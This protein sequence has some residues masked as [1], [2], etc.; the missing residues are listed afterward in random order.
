MSDHA[1][2][3]AAT[4]ALAAACWAVWWY[5]PDLLAAL[6]LDDLDIP[7]RVGAVI[8]FLTAA[9]AAIERLRKR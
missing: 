3:A 4:V 6:G 7:G 9:E 5:A 8:L 1:S 2:G